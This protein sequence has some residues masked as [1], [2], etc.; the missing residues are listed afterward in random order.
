MEKERGV[1]GSTEAERDAGKGRLGSRAQASE[2][3]VKTFLP[4][5]PHRRPRFPLRTRPTQKPFLGLLALDLI[6]AVDHKTFLEV[7][8]QRLVS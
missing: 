8:Q 3:M 4:S 5:L 2:V 7:D 1:A 6:R